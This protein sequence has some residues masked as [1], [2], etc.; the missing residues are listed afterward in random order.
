MKTQGARNGLLEIAAHFDGKAD[1]VDAMIIRMQSQLPDRNAQVSASARH[2]SM[3][4]LV[5]R[6]ARISADAATS[7]F[8]AKA[9]VRLAA[10]CARIFAS[11]NG[12]SSSRA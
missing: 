5:G 8:P 7:G 3:R 2:F 12:F 1:D 4:W 6:D 10:F 11:R 9:A